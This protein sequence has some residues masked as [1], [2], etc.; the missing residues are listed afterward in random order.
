M[1]GSSQ[2]LAFFYCYAA[3][4]DARCS[5]ASA[6]CCS[7]AFMERSASV[8][9]IATAI[10][11]AS[12]RV[13]PVACMHVRVSFPITGETT[14]EGTALMCTDEQRSN[15]PVLRRG[16]AR[17]RRR[18]RGHKVHQ[19]G[20]DPIVLVDEVILGRRLVVRHVV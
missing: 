19:A 10:A 8:F 6:S 18:I 7:S 1:V 14:A 4:S 16:K 15:L 13:F 3:S 9:S 17:G 11:C 12:S 5:R 2:T 20:P